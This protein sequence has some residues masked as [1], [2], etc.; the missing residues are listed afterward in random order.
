LNRYTYTQNDPV[1]FVDR[2]GLEPT[3][4]SYGNDLQYTMPC[5]DGGA[6]FL[7]V[8]H[9]HFDGFS[10]GGG[11]GGHETGHTPPQNTHEKPTCP[12]IPE[13]PPGANI[14]ANINHE[15]LSLA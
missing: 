2:M 4:C 10:G 15:A 7:F 3:I 8:L 11:G 14:D 1:N 5:S 9:S 12:P 13:A 6:D